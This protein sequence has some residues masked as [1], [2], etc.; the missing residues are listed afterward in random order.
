M[1]CNSSV[2]YQAIGVTSEAS[3]SFDVCLLR[4]KNTSPF[5][6]QPYILILTKD[7]YSPFPSYCFPLLSL[8]LNLFLK[9]CVNGGKIRGF[10][11]L[12]LST[13]LAN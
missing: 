8:T 3:A 6:L 5:L 7:T 1:F 9:L 13:L 2:P 10:E 4:Y 11:L 12:S